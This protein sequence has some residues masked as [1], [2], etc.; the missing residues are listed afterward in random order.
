MDTYQIKTRRIQ[1]SVLR[2]RTGRPAFGNPRGRS[3]Q[4]KWRMGAHRRR[5][6]AERMTAK[7]VRFQS[8]MSARTV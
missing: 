3:E 7:L 4:T 2:R 5:V 1:S 6:I 8:A